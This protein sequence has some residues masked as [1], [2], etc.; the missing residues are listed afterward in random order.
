MKNLT[1]IF[2]SFFEKFSDVAQL[3]KLRLGS[4]V[5]FSSVIAYLA[6]IGVSF[7]WS[8]LLSLALGGFLVTGASNAFNQILERDVDALMLRTQNRPLPS[9]R[10]N[11]SEACLWAGVAALFGLSLLTFIFSPLVGMLSALSLITYAFIYTPLK[12]VHSIAVFVG[13]IPGALPPLIGV[14]AAKGV[15]DYLAIYL[16]ILQFIWQF[17]HFWAIAWVSFEDY[18]RGNIMLLPST[19][20]RN[21]S[22]AFNI[23]FYAITLLII[24]I[25][26]F[27]FNEIQ[28][29]AFIGL[30]LAASVFLKPGVSLTRTL[31]EKDA[32]K[33]MFASFIYLPLALLVVFFDKLFY[34]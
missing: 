26:L 23:L 22:S 1:N 32:K 5:V 21:K 34:L 31:A 14:V 25:I 13:A 7:T 17:P 33:V 10:M 8:K 24:P 12:R 30:I 4:F 16:F 15:I 27:V 18:K 29:I 19:G 9:G 28:W 3:Y 6:A 20:G 2:Y 11:L